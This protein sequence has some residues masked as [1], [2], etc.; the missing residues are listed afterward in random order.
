[1]SADCQWSANNGLKALFVFCMYV[2]SYT[3]ACVHISN[4]LHFRTIDIKI[5]ING[6]FCSWRGSDVYLNQ[7]AQCTGH[8]ALPLGSVA[9]WV[10]PEVWLV[11]LLGWEHF[12]AFLVGAVL[13]SSHHKVSHSQVTV[14][15][16]TSVVS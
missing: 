10:G 8:P 9:T 1:M 15:A 11:P 3:W 6:S 16:G 7:V 5:S 4:P 2:C 12:C 13:T 14:T